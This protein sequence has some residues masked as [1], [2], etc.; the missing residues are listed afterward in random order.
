MRYFRFFY[1]ERVGKLEKRIKRGHKYYF[2]MRG[3]NLKNKLKKKMTLFWEDKF[4]RVANLQKIWGRN[5]GC[6][7]APSFTV[8]HTQL[9]N[10]LLKTGQKGLTV[11]FWSL[12]SNSAYVTS[13][14]PW[15]VTTAARDINSSNLHGI[16]YPFGDIAFRKLQDNNNMKR[17]KSC[18]LTIS[19]NE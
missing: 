18:V 5:Q 9:S 10:L 19:P 6:R 12:W 17:F 4:I 13:V 16:A 1:V 7:S 8:C 14:L 11:Y 15:I 2:G 3:Q